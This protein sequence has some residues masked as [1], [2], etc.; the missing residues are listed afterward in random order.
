M[1]THNET[2]GVNSLLLLAHYVEPME[3]DNWT[4]WETLY[5]VN[6]R[7][8]FTRQCHKRK[9]LIPSTEALLIQ[10]Q[11]QFYTTGASVIP[12]IGGEEEG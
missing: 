9:A 8:V 5:R 7:Q 2:A 4:V 10:L 6:K 3:N 1:V 11:S 12:R